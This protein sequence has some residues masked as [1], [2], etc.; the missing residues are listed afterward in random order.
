MEK[1]TSIQSSSQVKLSPI[2]A[3]MSNAGIWQEN[4]PY[5]KLLITV[6]VLLMS[7]V[8]FTAIAAIF[9]MIIF[10]VAP[11]DLQSLLQNSDNPNNIPALKLIQ[12][13]WAVGTFVVPAV[14]LA[15]LF[16]LNKKEYLRL[17]NGISATDVLL[18]LTVM[19]AA[20]PLINYLAQLNE[21]MSFP[22]FLQW[23]ENWIKEKESSA[24]VATENFLQVQSVGGLIV[25]VLII[26]VIPAIGE[27]LL[28]R[29]VLQRIFIDWFKSAFAAILLSS[30]LFSAM[31][32]QFYG[33]LPR[34]MLGIL[35]GYLLQ[36]SGSLW[37][38]M[39]AHFIN[40]AAQVI[41]IYFYRKG[42]MNIDP[43]KVGAESVSSPE[44]LIGAAFFTIALW[45]LYRK[46][47]INRTSSENN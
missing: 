10:H 36:W 27:E 44:L 31:H 21:K 29:G 47:K 33:F 7:T 2:F 41:A 16:S 42:S 25:N 35:L 1:E 32:L 37:L 30:I 18:I 39:V 14:I 34:M 22:P 45:L 11:A 13:I 28:F 9:V 6:G 43:D 5:S 17:D 3:R 15:N 19:F 4:T 20:F 12:A 38:P 8:A 46:H 24:K 40:N 26:A 23:L